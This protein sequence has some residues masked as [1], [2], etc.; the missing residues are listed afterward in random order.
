M[1]FRE[2]ATPELLTPQLLPRR[3]TCR[4]S[5]NRQ[6]GASPEM[7]DSITRYL[8]AGLCGLETSMED[9]GFLLRSAVAT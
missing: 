4:W 5:V 7:A 6:G 1:L 2:L 9:S 3:A 8:T